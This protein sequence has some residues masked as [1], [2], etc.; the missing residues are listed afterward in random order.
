MEASRQD[1]VSTGRAFIA[2]LADEEVTVSGTR[3]QIYY[4]SL[5]APTSSAG[6]SKAP[7]F[8][9]LASTTVL[10]GPYRGKNLKTKS[11]EPLSEETIESF[12]VET[13]QTHPAVTADTIL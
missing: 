3:C 10:T 9:L 6:V 1:T 4:K 7:V 13:E 11:S 12:S 8:E 5:L 2:L